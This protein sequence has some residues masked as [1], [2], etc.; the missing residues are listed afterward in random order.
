[1]LRS[2]QSGELVR[3]AF[4]NEAALVHDGETVAEPLRLFHVVGRIQDGHSSR[5]ELFDG[6]KN[7][8]AG[9]RIEPY[10]G[11]IEQEQLGLVDQSACKIESTL[12]PTGEVGDAIV[13]TGC[14]PGE[15]EHR[16]DACL[17]ARAL[18]TVHSAEKPQVL[19]RAQC[20]IEAN[21]LRNQAYLLS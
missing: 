13:S 5:R 21:L 8:L 17:E 2:H 10:R 1:L 12:H 19:F 11:L 16:L 6:G 15:L 7:A 4:G 14:E 3:C 9:L 20:G 18:Q